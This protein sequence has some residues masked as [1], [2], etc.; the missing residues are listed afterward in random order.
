MK[1]KVIETT[2]TETNEVFVDGL[3]VGVFEQITPGSETYSFMS[4]CSL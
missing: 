2:N 4:K 3:L 1:A